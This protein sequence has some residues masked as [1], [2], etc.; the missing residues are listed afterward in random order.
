MSK[1]DKDPKQNSSLIGGSLQPQLGFHSIRKSM[2]LNLNSPA[3]LK[4]ESSSLLRQQ[5]SRKYE[6]GMS[7]LRMQPSKSAAASSA[8]TSDTSFPLP[9]SASP[10][11]GNEEKA[12]PE[13]PAGTF[14][15]G[16]T[17]PPMDSPS[18]GIPSMSASSSEPSAFEKR[19]MSSKRT[20]SLNKKNAQ[21][22]SE[23][24][25]RIFT[26]RQEFHTGE[27]IE[28]P[29]VPTSETHREMK[30]EHPA[31]QPS[32]PTVRREPMQEPPM[33]DL[34]ELM[35]APAPS[36]ERKQV[37]ALEVRQPRRR[38]GMPPAQQSSAEVRREPVSQAQPVKSEPAPVVQREE[39]E[40]IPQAQPAPVKEPVNEIEEEPEVEREMKA[41]VPQ[42]KP[43]KSESAPVVQRE[44]KN[45][46]PQAQP[47][48][49]ES[50]GE[51]QELSLPRQSH[52]G[53]NAMV[54]REMNSDLMEM[55]KGMPRSYR[56]PADQIAE[57]E[58]SSSKP[59]TNSE[60]PF[61]TF[62][63]SSGEP[64]QPSPHELPTVVNGKT[65]EPG[66]VQREPKEDEEEESRDS[67]EEKP[68]EESSV[69]DRIKNFFTPEK[70][71]QQTDSENKDE[72]ELSSRDLDELADALLPKVKQLL[73]YDME[74]TSFY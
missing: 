62:G 21:A 38:P 63:N 45:S 60:N 47:V 44:T 27:K 43:V 65:Q 29:S 28:K 1:I 70:E 23:G 11:G 20:N 33:A 71:E 31:P 74:R 2:Q 36:T 5:T 72:P 32:E 67:E 41:P 25:R 61:G 7:M 16:M 8:K 24:P 69:I 22:A 51:T 4:P 52:S 50:T 17:I 10:M 58:K 35:K 19:L 18:P 14:M 39:D 9:R 57:L 53:D 42:A 66:L 54:H 68:E 6:D 56:M 73:Q 13:V 12:V 37:G 26:S 55:L 64:G 15:S 46:V 3:K 40:P 49:T 48:K 34:S 59:Q 30:E